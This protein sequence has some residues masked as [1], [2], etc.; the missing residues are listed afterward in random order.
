MLSFLSDWLFDFLP[1]RVQLACLL[2][3]VVGI[4]V[5]VAYVALS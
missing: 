4:G 5:I 2:V 3:A 1:L